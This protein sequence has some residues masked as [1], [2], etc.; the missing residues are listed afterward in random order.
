MM[1]AA[2]DISPI[3]DVSS[4]L[5]LVTKLILEHDFQSYIFTSYENTVC[6]EQ[7]GASFSDM[8]MAMKTIA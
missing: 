7:C 6:L 1:I 8:L 3:K 4:P 5:D 2:A